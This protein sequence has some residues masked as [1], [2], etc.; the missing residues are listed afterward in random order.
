MKEKSKKEENK[1]TNTVRNKGVME[2]IVKGWELN[3]FV[4]C[5]S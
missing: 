3:K 5:F 1:Q 2:A 4:V